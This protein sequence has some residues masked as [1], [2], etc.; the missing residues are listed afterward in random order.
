MLSITNKYRIAIFGGSFDPI[1]NGHLGV[2]ILLQEK[3]NFDK[4]IF[5]PAYINPFKTKNPPKTTAKQRLQMIKLA[6]SEIKD[7][8]FEVSEIEILNESPSYTIDTIK[9]IE[10]REKESGRDLELFL[11]IGQDS[12]AKFGEWKNSNQILEKCQILVVQRFENENIV[13]QLV[14]PRFTFIDKKDISSTE[15]RN[16]IKSGR[17]CAHLMPK[18]VLQYIGDNK[19]YSNL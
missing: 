19:I 15:L 17:Y 7:Y 6:I 13:N 18:S 3:Y 9:N 12:L 5:I 14:D 16:R 4:I 10:K 8:H 2:A 11:V 1:H